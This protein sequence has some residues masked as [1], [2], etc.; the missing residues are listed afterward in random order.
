MISATALGRE[1]RITEHKEKGASAPSPKFSFFVIFLEVNMTKAKLEQ[2]HKAQQEAAAIR[3][4]LTQLQYVINSAPSSRLDGMPHEHGSGGNLE[5]LMDKKSALVTRLQGLADEVAQSVAEVEAW[6]E[7]EPHRGKRIVYRY[8]FL[9]GKSW[10]VSAELAGVNPR[11][12]KRWRA[13]LFE[14]IS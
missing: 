2:C 6:I 12:A 8:H 3:E 5:R 9:C 10:A 14:E 7:A 11:T 4:T 1:R 13:K